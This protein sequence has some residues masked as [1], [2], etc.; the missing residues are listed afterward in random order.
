MHDITKVSQPK[1]IGAAVRIEAKGR[2]YI[3]LYT[4]SSS[5]HTIGIYDKILSTVSYQM[6]GV[7]LNGRLQHLRCSDGHCTV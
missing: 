5:S 7:R 1:P 4:I 3:L 2:K 6:A